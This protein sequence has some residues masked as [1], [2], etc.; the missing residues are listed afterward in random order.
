MNKLIT[1]FCEY[2]YMYVNRL[3]LY[4][5]VYKFF[6]LALYSSCIYILTPFYMLK[7]DPCYVAFHD[8]EWGLPVHD[9]KYVLTALFASMFIEMTIP[10]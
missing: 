5:K 6:L 9:D 1:T 7:A 10:G 2:S 3:I 8:E 4:S